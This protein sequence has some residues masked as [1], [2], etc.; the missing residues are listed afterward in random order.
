MIDL[1][2]AERRGAQL[3]KIVKGTDEFI[4]PELVKGRTLSE[5]A[6]VYSFGQLLKRILGRFGSTRLAAALDDLARRCID[7]EPTKRPPSFWEVA[8]FIIRQS[9]NRTRVP[10]V[11][12]IPPALTL[13]ILSETV[14][15]LKRMSTGEER[16][17]PPPESSVEFAWIS[18]EM[19]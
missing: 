15:S 2:L 7:P 19:N 14:Q 1:G 16:K 17:M 5:T 8:L 4:A 12:Y 18:Q 9:K 3:V 13:E 11:I 10:S 6:D